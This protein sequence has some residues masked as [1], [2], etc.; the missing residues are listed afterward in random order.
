MG[1]KYTYQELL[2]YAEEQGFEEKTMS[3]QYWNTTFEIAKPTTGNVIDLTKF[4]IHH[5]SDKEGD[6][7]ILKYGHLIP[8]ILK[9][10]KFFLKTV[11]GKETLGYFV[12]HNDKVNINGKEASVPLWPVVHN[13]FRDEK[14]SYFMLLAMMLACKEDK[15][16]FVM[17]RNK[18]REKEG[19][20]IYEQ[21]EEYIKRMI[22]PLGETAWIEEVDTKKMKGKALFIKL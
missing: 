17:L 19:E 20:I 3:L 4:Y 7:S 10:M 6:V 18:K 13:E 21:R 1:K 16:F 15:M 8:D 14:I 2:K 11:R 22:K 12:M 9:R 5:G